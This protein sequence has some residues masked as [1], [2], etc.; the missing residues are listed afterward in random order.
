MFLILN[1]HDVLC[2]AVPHV[3]RASNPT[4]TPTD[5]ESSTQKIADEFSTMG[6][7]LKTA[8]KG[9]VSPSKSSARVFACGELRHVLDM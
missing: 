7:D 6:I 1:M 9:K 8:L 2:C 4:V 3:Y 5:I